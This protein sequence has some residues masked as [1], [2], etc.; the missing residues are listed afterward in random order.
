MFSLKRERSEDTLLKLE[1]PHTDKEWSSG[2]RAS[3]NTGQESVKGAT[4]YGRVHEG[5]EGLR[6]RGENQQF[7]LNTIINSYVPIYNFSI[8]SKDRDNFQSCFKWH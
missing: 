1:R 3:G 8:K 6:R 2:G 4:E 5:A 7:Y